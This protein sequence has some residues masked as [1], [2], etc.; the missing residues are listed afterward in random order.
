[1]CV[2]IDNQLTDG[3]K[4]VSLMRQLAALYPP[5]ILLVLI[6]AKG[7]VDPRA[8]LRLVGLHQLKNPMTSSGTEPTTFQLVA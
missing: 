4:A 6:S 7:R 5:G 8:I 2:Y 3:C 1:M